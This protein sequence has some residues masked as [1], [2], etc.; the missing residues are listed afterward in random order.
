MDPGRRVLSSKSPATK[1]EVLLLEDASNTVKGN[2]SADR[3]AVC[4]SVL[5]EVIPQ[6]GV[7]RK[8]ISML[9][10]ELYSGVYSLDYTT[11]PPKKRA[12]KTPIVQRVPFFV[13]VERLYEQRDK[14]AEGLQD[15]ISLLNKD[16]SAKENLLKERNSNIEEL[17]QK[18]RSLED[19]N[20]QL[21][22]DLENCSLEKM[23]LSA[24]LD[25]EKRSHES[26]KA[27]YEKRLVNIREQLD[28]SEDSV[29][30][31]KQYKEGYDDLQE[32]FNDPNVFTKR[33]HKPA[34]LT[35]KARVI[36]EIAAAKL[37]EEQLLTM[38]NV[39]IEEYDLFV[40]ENQ[41][42]ADKSDEFAD[43]GQSSYSDRWSEESRAMKNFLKQQAEVEKRF[44]T[45][46]AE[47]ENELQLIEIQK[48]TLED[49]LES[50]VKE[51]KL[52][53]DDPFQG[54]SGRKEGTAIRTLPP[55]ITPAEDEIDF[56]KIMGTPGHADP[57]IPHERVMSKYSAML[58]YSCNH[59]KNFHEFKDAKFCA[60]CGETTLLCPHKI[61]EEKLV[62]L[63]HNC[64]HIKVTRPV[65]RILKEKE[66]QSVPGSPDLSREPSAGTETPSY[67]DEHIVK[68]QQHLTTSY[69]RL[70]DDLAS[71]S[72]VTRRIPRPLIKE[73][74][75]S[76]IHQFYATLL[77]Q[78]DFAMEE[79]QVVSVL[80]VLHT[81]FMDRYIISD[82]AHLAMHDFL[83]GVVKYAQENQTVQVFA[84]AMCGTLDPVVIRYI[85]L[86]NDFIDL[87]RWETVA[88]IRPF[89]ETVYP[90]MHEE[91]LEQFTMG[92]TSHSENKISKEL[93]SEYL[94]YIILKY[95]EPS[96]QDTEVK[97]LQH[98]GNRPGL[99]TDIEFTEAIDNICPL[100]SERLR[101][102]LFAESLEHM[103]DS[104]DCVNVTR[105]SQITGY[106]ALVQISSVV[107]D[108]IR[109]KVD[110]AR[111]K[112]DED[113]SDFKESIGT[114]KKHLLEEEAKSRANISV[115]IPTMGKLRTVAAQNSK[116][117]TAR[118]LER[119]DNF[120]Y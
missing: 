49:K 24:N 110:E 34:P 120:K 99:M 46:I 96:F 60:S 97:L 91:D 86:M 119:V 87:V 81:F 42:L 109:Q 115:N 35:R 15:E 67:G 72:S 69:K 9:R 30:Q 22:M 113:Q 28:K 58:Y 8:I 2:P 104:D 68:M 41:P 112:P 12:H 98:P 5:D 59:G 63:P 19:Q 74:V 55:R 77:W 31:L 3:M 95:R 21:T 105:L 33:P 10:E 47:I 26:S 1:Y 116:R 94:L 16:L 50:I 25:E 70:W 90:F 13:L 4:F 54:A 92:Y 56:V 75:L 118:Q 73:R 85:L 17:K 29:R 20:F 103:Q 64:T 62:S 48:S 45:N 107:K 80:D 36:Q 18:V 82:V 61:I 39:I 100:A 52:K 93:V 88:D 117:I 71:R 11:I 108:Y 65:V 83:A 14:T 102:R 23:K 44:Q 7:Y 43:K 78:D 76:I 38:Q 111:D 53:S 57:F 66:H 51:E 40:E 89:A 37:L 79:E 84:Q 27:R 6:L 32:A 114:I 101:R 106:L